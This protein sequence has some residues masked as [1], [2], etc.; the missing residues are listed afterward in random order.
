MKDNIYLSFSHN[1]KTLCLPGILHSDTMSQIMPFLHECFLHHYGG[2]L[3]TGQ[4]AS[5]SEGKL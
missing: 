4:V 2:Q 3:K 1:Q 5:R